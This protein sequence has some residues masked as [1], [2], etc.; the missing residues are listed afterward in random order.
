LSFCS[1]CKGEKIMNMK[2]SL[3]HKPKLNISTKFVNGGLA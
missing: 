2:H 1:F 3:K